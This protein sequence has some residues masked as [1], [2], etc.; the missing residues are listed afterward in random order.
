MMGYIILL[1]FGGRVELGFVSTVGY[2]CFLDI[3][4]R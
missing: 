3:H 2:S 1:W 4:V